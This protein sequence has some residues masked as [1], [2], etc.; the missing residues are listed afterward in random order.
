MGQK[1]RWWRGAES[2]RR[3]KDFQ[4]FA[5]PTEL[6]SHLKERLLNLVS[7]QESIQNALFAG[8]YP[9]K[10]SHKLWFKGAS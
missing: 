5:L 9:K 4:S 7:R 1:E 8:D 2:N 3:H 10:S 6:P